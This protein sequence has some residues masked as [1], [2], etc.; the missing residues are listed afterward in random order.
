MS[1]GWQKK[2]EPLLLPARTTTK[3]LNLLGLLRLDNHLTIYHSERP[4]TGAFM[5]ES[6]TDFV[7]QP[8][9][10]PVVIVLDNGPIHRCQLIY[11]QQAGWEEKDVYLFFL[12]TYSPH[13]N[14]IEILWRFI[15]YHWLHKIHYL[16]WSRLIKAIFTIIKAFGQEYH[17]DFTDLV[18]KNTTQFNSA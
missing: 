17:I 2:H 13:L 3:R 5:V 6:L 8:H 12:P 18:I 7:G 15:K 14:P 16:S 1:Y 10:K 11:D 9:N 4:L